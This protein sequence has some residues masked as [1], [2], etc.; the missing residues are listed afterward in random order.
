MCHFLKPLKLPQE[1]SQKRVTSVS[2][3]VAV[4]FIMFMKELRRNG[5]ETAENRHLPPN[6]LPFL[7]ELDI[8][9]HLGPHPILFLSK[10]IPL[11]VLHLILE[12]F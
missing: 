4:A 1:L 8:F 6:F 12:I 3:G 7:A 5:G 2:F 11:H 9:N 10:K